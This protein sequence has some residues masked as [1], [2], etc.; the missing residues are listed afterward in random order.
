MTFRNKSEGHRAILWIDFNGQPRDYAALAE[1]QSWTVKTY[2]THPWM[3][4][5]GPGNCLEMFMP[6]RGVTH[7]DITKPNRYFGPE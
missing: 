3:I 1:G 2:L 6:K 7:F 4:T 5:D